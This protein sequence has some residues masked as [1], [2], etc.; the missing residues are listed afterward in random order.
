M[1]NRASLDLDEIDAYFS[2]RAAQV[3]EGALDTRDGL[4]HLGQL[5]LLGLGAPSNADGHLSDMAWLIAAV[6]E[7]CTSSAFSLW[8]HRMVIEYLQLGGRKPGQSALLERLL[9][10]EL[11]GATAMAAALR[12]ELGLGD[13]EVTFRRDGD[14]LV[15]DGRVR[16]ASNLF[17]TG[18]LVVLA[19]RGENGDRVVVALPSTASGLQVDDYPELLALGSTG[20]SSLTLTDVKVEA[21]QVLTE[22]V[23]GFMA[24]MRG[25]FLLLQSAFCVGLARVALREGS[26][27]LGGVNAQFAE[28]HA[29]LSRRLNAASLELAAHCDRRSWSDVTTA[30]LS[31]RLAA[32]ELA[33]EAVGLEAKVRG[34][35]GYVQSSATA[36]RLR[37]AAFLPIQSPTEAQLRWE[38]ACSIS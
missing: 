31:L 29:A 32:A 7:R 16:W 8:A 37:E 30:V 36:R 28:L 14:R 4:G 18:F 20:S 12:D 15:L 6:A 1:S 10:G 38:L 9:S 19:A 26:T 21:D 2:E 5:G 11:P 35:A 22:D 34:G 23:A 13:L 27:R 17:P 3:D 33:H 24:A 25:P